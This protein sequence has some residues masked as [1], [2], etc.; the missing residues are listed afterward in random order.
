MSV[1]FTGGL[2]ELLNALTGG[3]YTEADPVSFFKTP[4]IN[5]ANAAAPVADTLTSLWLYQ[6]Q[7]GV[8][9]A[10][11]GA[12]AAPGRAS[13]G[14]LMQ[15]DPGGGRK[16]YLV[17]IEGTCSAVGQLLLYDRLLHQSGLDATNTGAQTVGGSI[18]RNT[19]GDGNRL[20][21]EVYAQVGATPTTIAAS[22]TNQAGTAGRLTQ[23]VTF[24]GAGARE[25]ARMI[26]MPL[27]AGDYGVRSV[28]SVTV[29]AT[30]GTAGDFGLTLAHPIISASVGQLAAAYCKA[31]IAPPPDMKELFSDACLA[32][33]FYS[34]A[35]TAIELTG[36]LI[37]AEK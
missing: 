13:N 2:G 3:A 20:Y 32:L 4:R 34:L 17:S 15:A 30:T 23:A 1:I 31:L 33:A 8:P 27:Q 25:Q 12:V 6:G 19:G 14:G 10:A 21:A 11:P 35:N 28:Q 24:G 18:T 5:D 16:S 9:L 26:K 36:Q 37:V 22:Y 29:L 7:P